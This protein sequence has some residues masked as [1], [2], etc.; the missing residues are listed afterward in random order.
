MRAP[1]LSTSGRTSRQG[2]LAHASRSDILPGTKPLMMM[3][4]RQSRH[5]QDFTVFTVFARLLINRTVVC[6]SRRRETGCPS[7]LMKQFDS[8]REPG[9]EISPLCKAIVR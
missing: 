4:V 2:L 7:T 9:L 1:E 8:G 5:D 3:D 6:A